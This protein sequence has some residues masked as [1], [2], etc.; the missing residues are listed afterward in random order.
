MAEPSKITEKTLINQGEQQFLNDVKMMVD[1]YEVSHHPLA[2]LQL[3]KESKEA[4]D[5]M[6]ADEFKKYR[7]GVLRTAV[8]KG[9][10]RILR[11]L[12][13]MQDKVLVTAVKIL[14]EHL[15]T[16]QG[17]ATQRVEVIKRGISPEQMDALIKK[18]PKHIESE[19]ISGRGQGKGR[20][21]KRLD[22]NVRDTAKDS[23]T[24]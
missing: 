21:S 20:R 10:A 12:P 3:D 14:S 23:K 13:E 18:L 17:D 2:L 7:E 16:I 24:D 5:Q 1:P 8:L 6:T 22:G 9:E 11:R 15:S 19:D 4:L